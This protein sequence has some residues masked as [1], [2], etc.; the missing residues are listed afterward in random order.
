MKQKNQKELTPEEVE[1]FH[2]RLLAMRRELVGDISYM[3]GETLENDNRGALSSMP[4]HM[5]DVGTD[6]YEQEFALDLL[7]SERTMLKEIDTALEKVAN[8]TYGVCEGTGNPI[9]RARLDAKPYA[10]YCIDFK[11]KLEKGLV[12]PPR[13]DE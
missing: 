9:G 4:V 5:A 8:D 1:E 6:N 7:D 12:Q 3:N 11:D 2:Q 10:R 13:D